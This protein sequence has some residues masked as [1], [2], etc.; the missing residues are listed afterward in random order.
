M[1][2]VSRGKPKSRPPQHN[3]AKQGAKQGASP[4]RVLAMV[5][6]ACA[7]KR[8]PEYQQCETQV[9]DC[10]SGNATACDFTKP[11][12]PKNGKKEK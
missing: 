7:D 3:G 5:Q 9:R 11:Y 1:S 4:E 6:T 8:G 2:S 12:P 10:L